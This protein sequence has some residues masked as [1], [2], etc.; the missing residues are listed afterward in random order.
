VTLPNAGESRADFPVIDASDVAAVRAAWEVASR[1][2][3]I[4][5]VS[6]GQL[7][8]GDGRERD[9]VAVVLDFGGDEGMAILPEW[10]PSHA[11][12]AASRGFGYTVLGVSYETFDRGLMGDLEFSIARGARHLRSL[13]RSCRANCITLRH[14]ILQTKWPNNAACRGHS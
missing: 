11:E 2:L 7:Q 5:V 4:R 14:E 3:G 6:D 10:D 1:E 9:L 13:H 8:D 12:L